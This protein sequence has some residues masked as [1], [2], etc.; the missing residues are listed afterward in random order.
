MIRVDV[1]RRDRLQRALTVRA[2]DEDLA[3][4]DSNRVDLSLVDHVEVDVEMRDRPRGRGMT[5]RIPVETDPAERQVVL[6]QRLRQ[7]QSQLVIPLALAVIV[8][9]AILV[10]VEA[11]ARL[12]RLGRQALQRPGS[13]GDA[14]RRGFAAG[15]GDSYNFV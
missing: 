11:P 7:R 15:S 1:L 14:D 12:V 8:D 2:I 4:A 10:Q 13:E 3:A 5:V 9:A 6:A